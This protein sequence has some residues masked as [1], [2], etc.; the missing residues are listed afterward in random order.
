MP[1][2]IKKT[3]LS[4]AWEVQEAKRFEE[5]ATKLGKTASALARELLTSF[6]NGE[7][8]LKMTDAMAEVYE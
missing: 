7:I 1:K 4:F 5:N 8:K 2:I 3:K 6:N